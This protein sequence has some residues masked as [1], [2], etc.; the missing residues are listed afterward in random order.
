MRRNHLT[1]PPYLLYLWKLKNHYRRRYKRTRLTTTHQVY[2][3]LTQVFST[4]LTRHRNFKWS[5]FLN[6]LQPQTIKFWKT[7]RYIT[8]SPISIPPPNSPGRTS[9]PLP[10]QSRSLS[11][12]VRALPSSHP[13]FGYPSPLQ[14]DN[15][16]CRQIFSRH[17]SPHSLP[18]AHETLRN[19]T[20]NYLSKT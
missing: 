9:L 4:Y 11:S 19:Q 6:S 3:L 7:T 17:Q 2:L 12:T 14:K 20:Q 13:Q 16:T 5:S 8:K 10:T 1:L 15:S 18:T